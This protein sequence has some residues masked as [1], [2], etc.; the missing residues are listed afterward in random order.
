MGKQ[1]W[2]IVYTVYSAWLTKQIKEDIQSKKTYF[3]KWKV[4]SNELNRRD[5]QLYQNKCKSI[6]RLVK[7]K[8][9]WIVKSF[10]INNKQ[11]HK[12]A[13]SRKTGRK[14]VRPWGVWEQG[15]N[16]S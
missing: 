10:K 14:L 2:I 13:Q 9:E 16:D 3:K 12:Y 4:S 5:H 7:R 8:Q 1:T 15:I 6:S 11:I